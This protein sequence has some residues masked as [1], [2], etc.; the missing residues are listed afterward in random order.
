MKLQVR[1]RRMFLRGA[2]GVLLAIPT[3]PSLLWKAARVKA[4]DITT[5]VRYVQWVTNHGVFESHFWPASTYSPSEPAS[6]SGDTL[7]NV[8][9]RSLSDIPERM[10]AV[11][12]E[13]FDPVRAKMN[14]IRGLDLMVGPGFHNAGV[15]TCASWPRQDNLIPAFAHSVDSILETSTKFYPTPVRT[16][17]LRLTPG[18]NPAATWG[19]FCW[20]TRA[21]KPIRLT[22]YNSPQS[23]LDEVFAGAKQVP[24]QD[25]QVATLRM[26][27]QVKD[28]YRHVS[29]LS[30]LGSADRD[31]LSHYIDLLADV[32]RRMAIDVSTC[33]TPQLANQTDFDVLHKNAIDIAVAAMLCGATRVVCYHCYQ[34]SPSQYDESSFHAWCHNDKAKHRELMTYRYKQLARMLHTMDQVKEAN[35]KTL[36]DNSLVYAGNE[37]SDPAHGTR[38]LQNMPVILAGSA[39]G[40]LTTGNYIDYSGRLFNN[41][42]ISIFH[43]LGLEP[44]DYERGNVIGFGD[45]QGKNQEN[46]ARYLTPEERRKSLPLL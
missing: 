29:K 2:G 25:A 7:P 11:L 14:L 27:D 5:P 10:S 16:P 43:V 3:L 12:S 44:T 37:L 17:A 42:L 23:A 6:V 30:A 28:D 32:Q 24:R 35:G 41:L 26:V 46:Y 45:Y 15:P 38:H 18:V 40:K 34:G 1:S 13:S 20:T 22:A 8:K 39:G 36:L 4:Q 9:A 21:G 33:R 19:S 31:L